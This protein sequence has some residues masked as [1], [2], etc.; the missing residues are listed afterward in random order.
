MTTMNK[1]YT[2]IGAENNAW[3]NCALF[4]DKSLCAYA[5]KAWRS[6]LFTGSEM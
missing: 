2:V 4:A 1:I 5:P 6:A 3:N